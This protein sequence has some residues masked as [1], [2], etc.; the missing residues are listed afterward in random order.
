MKSVAFSAIVADYRETKLKEELETDWGSVVFYRVPGF[1]V[2]WSM[3]RLGATPNQLTLAGMVLIPSMALAAWFL[4]PQQA[5]P[6]VTVLA[7][8]FNVLDCADGPL[9]RALNR[10]SLSGR[11]MDAAADIFYRNTAY[12]CYGVIADRIWPGAAFPW[13]AVGLCCAVLVTY[14]R[15]NRLYGEKLFPKSTETG[16]PRRRNAFDV[17]FSILSGFDTL[18]PVIAFVAWEGGMLWAALVWFLLYTLGDAVVEVTG[19]Y[20]KARRIEAG[21]VT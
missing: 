20:Q 16:R 15:V 19:N 18:L 2:A 13:L 9:A 8:A 4:P 6:V 12:A 10:S 14:A 17:A 5:V 3:A 21:A 1:A 11:Y 7:L